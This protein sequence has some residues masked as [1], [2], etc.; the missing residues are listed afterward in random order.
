MTDAGNL[1]I[2]G[3][4]FTVANDTQHY[5]V[6]TVMPSLL[7]WGGGSALTGLGK[8]NTTT[9]PLYYVGDDIAAA[10]QAVV[11][12]TANVRISMTYHTA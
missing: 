8:I 10:T 9:I 3:L 5:A 7:N 1:E 4:P 6:A 12:E 11:N 2:R